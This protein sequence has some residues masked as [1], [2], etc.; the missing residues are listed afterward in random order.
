MKMSLR[1]RMNMKS[2]IVGENFPQSC[3]TLRDSENLALANPGTLKERWVPQYSRSIAVAHGD[4]RVFKEPAENPAVSAP[5]FSKQPRSEAWLLL[6][7]DCMP[8]RR[9]SS[10]LLSG[11]LPPLA[12]WSQQ[13]EQAIFSN[14]RHFRLRSVG[15]KQ[16]KL[17][18][19]DPET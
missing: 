1:P 18:S 9:L 5:P 10:G 15:Q 7:F 3:P 11:H 16:Y 8:Q 6:Q 14:R 2:N 19:H 4:T 12:R 13:A 17:A